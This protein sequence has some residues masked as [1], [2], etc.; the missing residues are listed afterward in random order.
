MVRQLIWSVVGVCLMVGGAW[1]KASPLSAVSKDEALAWIRHTVPLPKQIEIAAKVIVPGSEVA[2]ILPDEADAVVKQAARELRLTLGQDPE[3]PTG[4]SPSFTITLEMEGSEAA[5]LRGLRNS[6]QAYRIVPSA[7]FDG[8]TLAALTPRGLYYASKT[9]QQLLRTRTGEGRIEMPLLQVRDWPDMADRGLWGS[10]CHEHLKWLAERKMNI[11]E[12][13]SSMTVDEKGRGHAR[14]K[15][16]REPM[17][18]EGPLY[19]VKPVPAVL[20]LEQVS[21]KGVFQAYP[22]LKGQ[23]EDIHEGAICY[24]RPEFVH[25]LADWIADLGSLPGVEEVDVWMAE[26]MQGKPG[27]QCEGCKKEDRSVLEARVIVKAWREARKRIGPVG[28]RILTSEAT[29]DANPAVFAEYP[30]EVKIWYYH[31]LLTYTAGETPMLRPYLADAARRGKW[32]G[33]CPN[34]ISIVHFTQPFTGAHFIHYRMNEFVD[35]GMKGLIGYATP[36]VYY[37]FFNT[38]AAAEWSWNAKGRSPHEFALSWAVRNRIKDPDLFAEWSDT[39][40]PVAWDVYGSDWPNGEQRGNPEHVDARLKKGT[41]NELGT[42]LWQVY[43]TP[44]A[45]IK[46]PIHLEGDLVNAERGVELARQLNRPEFLYES[47]IVEGYVK[48]LKALWGL[49]GLVKE[50][51]VAEADRPA[52]QGYFQMFADSLGQVVET[53]PKWEATVPLRPEAEHHT[54]RPIKVIGEVVERM[55]QVASELGFEIKKVP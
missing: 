11:V 3:S 14:L 34:L 53:L 5:Q 47:L 16:G 23:G 2:V 48:S 42:D 8:L 40:G 33:V 37:G 25:V 13:I 26:N 39:V 21:G 51:K 54:D 28:L 17:V 15:G 30:D 7:M 46:N 44:W 45:D 20:H 12:Q 6:D 55:G 29:E 41:L 50:G 31:S 24:S 35:K 10:D 32:V 43:R 27:C 18:E 38:E 52:A 9:L 4:G 1:G 22:Q 49:K 19:G 36:R